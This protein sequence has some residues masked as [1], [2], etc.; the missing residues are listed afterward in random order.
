MITVDV[1][2][3]VS[4]SSRVTRA[5]TEITGFM[6]EAG[7]LMKHLERIMVEDN[8][9]GVLAG[10]DKDGNQAPELTYR[11]VEKGV[12][13]TVEQRLGQNPRKKRGDFY[14]VGKHQ[15]GTH[16]NLTSAEYRL[17]DGPR[18]A[19]RRQFSRV[20][21]NFYATSF[22]TNNPNVWVGVGGWREVVSPTEY[23]FLPVHFD[24]LPLGKNGPSKRYDLRGIRPEGMEQ[25]RLAL[26]A[27]AQDTVRRLWRSRVQSE[28]A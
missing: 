18:L 16:N 13:L 12:K 7:P 8:L 20:I 19:P 26:L 22:Q 2:K 14:G 21:T 17:L 25:F 1:S 3:V 28:A 4:A 9:R 27:W 23:H 10:T 6:N 11:P 15:S 24:G 5:L